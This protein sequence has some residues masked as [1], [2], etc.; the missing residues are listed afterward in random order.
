MFLR[1][2]IV[3][4]RYWMVLV[5]LVVQLFAQ[6]HADVLR[7][8]ESLM[9]QGGPYVLHWQ[10]NDKDTKRNSWPTLLGVEWENA[11]RWELGAA[12]FRNSF[13]QTSVY[14]YA[15]RRWFLP[16][17]ADGL[18][19]K[20][21]GGPLYGYRGEYE[22]KVPFNYNGLGLAVLPALGYQYGKANFQTV[23]LGTAAVIFTF[24]YEFD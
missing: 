14:V 21:T 17:V 22:K 11:D 2:F 12:V 19:V 24:G 7:D 20:L 15:G 8:G 16:Q 10:K 18:Y 6:V 5:L 3:C 1:Y 23:F 4:R 13:Y 9:L